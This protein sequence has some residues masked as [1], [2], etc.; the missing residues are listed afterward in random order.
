MSKLCVVIPGRISALLQ[1]MVNAA[2]GDSPA[3]YITTKDNIPDLKNKKIIFAV[4]V[5]NAGTNIELLQIITELFSRG[6]DALSGSSGAVIIHSPN[7]LYT[8]S[9]SQN[10]IFLTNQLGCQ[11]MGH[12]VME[13]TEGLINFRTWQK[14]MDLSFEEICLSL[15]SKLGKRL[16][17]FEPVPVLRPNI[18]ALHSSFRKT[19]NTLEL[20][21]MVCK[22]LQSCDITELHVENG[23]VLDC[24][25]CSYKTCIHYGM[26]NSC[27][28]GGIMV[29]DILP[30][31]QKAD[32]VVWVCPNYNDAISANLTAVINR[33]TALY[34]T[35]SFYK[36]TM[37]SI[38]VSGN[39]GSDTVARQLLG[40]L[41]INKGFRLPPYFSLMATA[42]DTG[43][44][45][46]V[47]D[48]KDL[49]LNFAQ[50]I[51][52]QTKA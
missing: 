28:Y 26:Q 33:L 49:A 50:N 31:I 52:S 39:S 38:I 19:S 45:K 1:D 6:P 11:Y 27:F 48:I 20:W 7:Q 43:E 15:C 41:N 10:L 21:H 12:P 29:K 40:A 22:N 5:N 47:R 44:I 3:E 35:T 4:E 46:K 8:K 34:R 9:V 13:A 16:L 25:G 2:L 42:N 37:F 24:K 17:E 14:S 51:I 30:A 18:L 32:A 36:K 23:D